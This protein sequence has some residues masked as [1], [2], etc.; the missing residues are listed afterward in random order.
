MEYFLL[1]ISAVFVN[2][3]VLA[4]Y[5]GQCAYLGCSKEKGV[6]LGMGAAVIFVMVIATPITWLL[7]YFV[8]IPLDLGYLQT[9][10]FILVIAAL[11]QIVEMFLK[12]MVPPLYKALGIF[13]PL[14]TTNCAVLGVAILVQRKEYDLATSTFYSFAS[15]TGFMLALVVLA[16]IRE[17]LEISRVPKAFA[18]VPVGLVM[19][20]IM[21]MSFMAFTGMIA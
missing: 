15:A 21:S 13:L 3:I 14:I 19:A 10:I 1:L 12:K 6:G 18:G 17:R 11:V 2:N 5:L 4:Q 7:Q 8:L 9:I 16:S 20:G